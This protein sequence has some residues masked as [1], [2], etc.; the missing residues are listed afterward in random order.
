MIITYSHK[1]HK[2]E[3]ISYNSII[4]F[5]INCLF[6]FSK[7]KFSC[8]KNNNTG[9]WSYLFLFLINCFF[10]N[11]AMKNDLIKTIIVKYAVSNFAWQLFV[12][13][14]SKHV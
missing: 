10:R 12:S 3:G 1:K 4:L 8:N 2:L 14:Q 11:F 9:N 13:V 7:K 5:C 6:C